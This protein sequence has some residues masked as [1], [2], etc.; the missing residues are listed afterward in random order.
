KESLFFLNIAAT[1]FLDLPPLRSPAAMA[2][3]FSSNNIM[4][5]SNF[6]GGAQP[7]P[8]RLFSPLSLTSPL[9]RTKLRLR[10]HL[11]ESV[12]LL[13]FD[14]L[15]S[16][17]VVILSH[18]SSRFLNKQHTPY[19]NQGDRRLPT[20]YEF[21]D[22]STVMPTTMGNLEVDSSPYSS[23]LIHLWR[24]QALDC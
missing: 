6:G 22:S 13:F 12:P 1:H 3:A 15:Q 17:V 9:L 8:P 10:P 19:A 21:G 7:S 16:T 18:S 14:E 11:F 5:P 20:R 2:L 23:F 4:S 24:I